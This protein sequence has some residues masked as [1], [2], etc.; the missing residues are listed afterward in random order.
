MINKKNGM[1]FT[2]IATILLSSKV[3]FVKF[4]LKD[5]LSA[6]QIL[7]LRMLF[8]TPIFLL[9]YLIYKR[10]NVAVKNVSIHVKIYIYIFITGL[11]GF[12]L[13]PLLDFQ[14]TQY[15]PATIERILIFTYPIFV[16]IFSLITKRVRFNIV[17]L[18]V[19]I[20]IMIG[21]FLS[22]GGFSAFFIKNTYKSGVYLV[23]LA[24]IFYAFSLIFSEKI[25]HIVGSIVLTTLSEISAFIAL[26]IY[27]IVI[28]KYIFISLLT[29]SLRSYILI[30]GMVIFST[31]IPF[32]IINECIKIVGATNVSLISVISPVFI[33][34]M[35][36]LML[37]EHI[38]FI[39]II[40]CIVILLSIL[41]MQL[42]SKILKE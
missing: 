4:T 20:G 14:G 15:V 11:F 7:L 8:A 29:I 6:D 33:S 2:I 9:I 39:Q 12:F 18:F 42:Y 36:V 19:L 26:V 5:G 23:L 22:I 37:K 40:G 38:G 41:G 3:L 16:F 28:N 1:F 17:N 34:F 32:F 35:D 27:N 21:L 10:K 30:F 25:V 31:V 24:S 13:S